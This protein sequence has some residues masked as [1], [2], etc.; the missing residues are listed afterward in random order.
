MAVPPEQPDRQAPDGWRWD[1]SLYEGSARYYSI[2]R[3]AYPPRL[4][5]EMVQALS[6]D[7]SGVLLDVGCGPGSLT[8]LL[9]PHV[10]RAVGVDPDPGMLAEAGRLAATQRVDNVSWRQ[11]RG[12][13]LPAD[14]PR[15]RVVTFAQSFHWMDRPRVAGAV[16]GML[17]A[18]CRRP[19]RC[20]DA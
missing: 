4:A 8:L 2:G 19:R 12:E 18:G 9:A 14:L 13:D 7:G 11:L 17:P 5:D 20:H 1:P 15:A 16:R 10:A 6:L 3:V